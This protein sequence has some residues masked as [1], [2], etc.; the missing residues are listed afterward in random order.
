MT[1]LL[2]TCLVLLVSFS[3]VA[4]AACTYPLDATQQQYDLLGNMSGADTRMPIINGQMVNFVIEGTGNTVVHT[5]YSEAGI[6][7]LLDAVNNGTQVGDWTLPTNGIAAVELRLDNAPV[8]TAGIDTLSGYEY[9]VTFYMGGITEQSAF[10][11]LSGSS[12]LLSVSHYSGNIQ[13]AIWTRLVFTPRGGT[14]QLA[15]FSVPVTL[16]LPAEFK[17]GL[18]FNADTR[19]IGYTVNGTDYGYVAIPVPDGVENIMFAVGGNEFVSLNDPVV[20]ALVGGEL[21]TEPTLFTEPFPAGTWGFC[22]APAP[23][24][25]TLPGGGAFPGAGDPPGLRNLPDL[26]DVVRGNRAP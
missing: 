17:L 19:Q 18:Y 14:P 11:S 15:S 16:P 7:S 6:N 12:S 24:P 23:E 9:G 21:I 10:D 25:I 2:S 20:G 4:R 8:L 13:Y 26:P 22:T 3:S 1:K 5:A